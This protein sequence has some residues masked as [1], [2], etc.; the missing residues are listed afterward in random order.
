MVLLS[1]WGEIMSMNRIKRKMRELIGANLKMMVQFGYWLGMFAGI[2]YAYAGNLFNKLV[3]L[4]AI[5]LVQQLALIAFNVVVFV[6][7]CSTAFAMLTLVVFGLI[8]FLL[9][10]LKA[11]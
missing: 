7:V 11:E 9:G 2:V 3:G 1:M 6:I 5:A 10:A 8:G 4:P